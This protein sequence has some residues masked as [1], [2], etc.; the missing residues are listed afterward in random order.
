MDLTIFSTRRPHPRDRARHA[1]ADIGEAQTFYLWP[2]SPGRLLWVLLVCFLRSPIGFLR[3]IALGFTLDV[4]ARP[5][6]KY[7]LP[8]LLPACNFAYE[9]RRR[10]IEHI[11]CHT[12]S[13]SAILC[14]MVR[15]L[16]GIP[17]SLIVN[18]NIEWWGG[19]MRQKFAETEF[20]LLCTQLMTDQMKRDYPEIPPERYALGRVGVDASVWTPPPGGRG[21]GT[22]VNGELRILSVSRLVKSK[23]QDVLLRAVALLK[24]ANI[25]VR[26]HI[27]G[28]GPERDALEALAVELQ[29]TDRATFLGFL[30]EDR[31]MEE[32]RAADV[33]VLA[34]HAEPM[35][36]VYM[37][38]MATEIA[39]VGTNAGGV[40]EII[41]DGVN[42][43]LVPPNDPQALADVLR[44]LDQDP[45]LRLQLG[46]AARRTILDEFDSRLWAAELYTRLTGHA[47]PSQ[48]TTGQDASSNSPP[49]S[50]APGCGPAPAAPIA[51]TT[52]AG[53]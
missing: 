20:T 45:Q 3:C 29:I 30:D 21:L 48:S 27:G 34:S 11:H 36:V 50:T 9:A 41:R 15:R 42:G 18:A 31:Y 10:G 13:K 2:M 49:R 6:W 22:R 40:P 12:A 53:V 46:Q 32:M 5:R 7:I 47:P 39:T 8:L 35:G 38:A 37:E 51:T 24:Q 44:R 26:L 1:F 17:F 19:A 43:L 52:R 28:D 23:G 25:P 4:E 14:M 33:F 16:T